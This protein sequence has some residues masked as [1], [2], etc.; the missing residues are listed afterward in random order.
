MRPEAL[1]PGTAAAA[2]TAPA[3]PGR[4]RLAGGHRAHR[5][6]MA[7][8]AAVFDVQ[9]APRA[10]EDILGPPD[11]PKAPA[12]ATNNKWVT[13]SVVD[14]IATVVAQGF[15]EAQRRDPRQRRTWLTLVDG[16]NDQ[17]NCIRS[18][19]RRR[20][21]QVTILVDFVHVLEYVWKAARC[22][23]A[24]DDPKGEDWVRE[25]GLGILDGRAALMAAAIRRK[26][27]A[28]HLAPPDRKAADECADYLLRKKAYLDYPT[29]LASGWPIAT[30]VIE[31]A[32]RHLVQDRMDITGARWGLGSAEAVLK[33][34][35]LRTNG[36][37]DRY[38]AFHL[39]QEQDR[40]H[41]QRYAGHVIPHN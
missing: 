22:F 20:H 38:W 12:P 26:A 17:L 39:A 3:A 28:A 7:E 35:A 11:R 1:R 13:V 31:G 14:D 9:P 37:F 5:K 21:V 8:I 36:D 33:I 32:C 10:K 34:R 40:V 18:Q 19:A 30:G 15:D 24:A 2:A 27:T 4:T 29:A 16:N 23:F 25:K 6:R 41:L